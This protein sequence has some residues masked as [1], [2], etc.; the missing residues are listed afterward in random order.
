[1]KFA[2]MPASVY[3]ELGSC[4]RWAAGMDEK[5]LQKHAAQKKSDGYIQPF[6]IRKKT[7]FAEIQ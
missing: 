1:M 6:L 5:D 2:I 7:A 3:T 4:R